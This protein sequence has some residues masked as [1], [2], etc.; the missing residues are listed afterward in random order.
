MRKGNAGGPRSPAGPALSAVALILGASCGSGEYFAVREPDLSAA[1][2]RYFEAVMESR[3]MPGLAAAVVKGGR[4]IYA[5]GFGVRALGTSDPVTPETVFHTASVSK[6]FVATAAMRLVGEGRLDL[7]APATRYV[8]HFRLAD[9]REN[10]IIIRQILSH[11]SGMPDVLDYG[12]ETPEYDAEALERYVRS[13]SNQR[14]LSDPGTT[15]KYSNMAY[16]VMGDILARIEQ[17]PFEE[18]IAAGIL[19]P[20]EMRHSSFL[21]FEHPGGDQAVPHRG[22]LSPVRAAVYPY[23]RA[24]APSSTLRSNALDLA[25]FAIA[26]LESN[27][28][29]LADSLK[30]LMWT[31]QADVDRELRMGFGWFLRSHRRATMVLAPGRDPGFNAMVALLPEQE[32]GVVLLSNYDGQSAFELVEVADGVLDI[33]LGRSPAL[34]K[35][36]IAIPVA[37]VLATSGMDAAIAEYRRLRA[38]DDPRY[39]AGMSDLITLGHDLRQTGR[40]DDAIRFYQ[41]NA[42]EQPEYFASH[43]ALAQAFLLKGDTTRAVASYRTMLSLNPE[44]FGCPESCYRDERLRALAQVR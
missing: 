19:T 42:E 13:L 12:W 27:R 4:V 9:G 30:Q 43:L 16:E 32:V 14:L 33:G 40:L 34:P 3:P 25:R 11:T 8:P 18:V 20:L 22:S 31:S 24:H 10:E 21:P 23:H 38:A 7:D 15:W 28:P 5:K 39:Q 17:L 2:D 36:S 37:R 35:A 26:M 41:L 29:L 1:L 6:A 44:R